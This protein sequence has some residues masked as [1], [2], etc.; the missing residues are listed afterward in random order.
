MVKRTASRRY[1]D[2]RT[3]AVTVRYVNPF[4][5]LRYVERE[6]WLKD[7]AGDD[8]AMYVGGVVKGEECTVL[9]INDLAV[10]LNYIRHFGLKV[11]GLP[12]HLP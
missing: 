5:G 7:Y 4:D 11:A 1:Y 2:D 8:Y 9:M 6:T 10:A 3:F 12:R